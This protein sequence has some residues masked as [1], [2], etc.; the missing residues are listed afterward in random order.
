MR[1]ISWWS[2]SAIRGFSISRR[3][4]RAG[5]LR[6]G[7]AAEGLL[8]RLAARARSALGERPSRAAARP[9][10][11]WRGKRGAVPALVRS[12]RCAAARQGARIFCRL[13][14]R[15]GKP[16]YLP[17]LPRT[18]A[19]VRDTCAR[20]GELTALHS[21]LEQRVV[22]QL[23]RANAQVAADLARAADRTHEGDAAGGRPRRA[24]ATDYRF[25]AEAPGA[26]GRQ[27]AHCLAPR[28]TGARRHPRGGHQ[29]LVAGRSGARDA[30]RRSRLRCVDYLQR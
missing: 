22:A 24:H 30:R 10:R 20:Y 16:G 15:D 21:F 7:V 2:G 27:A 9:G 25:D 1:A 17:D 19:Y 14:Y 4:A 28:G 13:W 11:R 23:S 8:H 18:L 5:G 29:S 6:S 3:A 12:H 26:G